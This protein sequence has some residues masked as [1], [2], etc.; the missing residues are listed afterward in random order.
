M[1]KDLSSYLN[2]LS[3]LLHLFLD[4]YLEVNII[5]SLLFLHY[6]KSERCLELSYKYSI[7]I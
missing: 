2:Y 1:T 3:Y 6:A 4:M 5:S 7:I